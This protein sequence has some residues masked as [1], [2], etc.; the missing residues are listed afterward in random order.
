[1]MINLQRNPAE[2][3]GNLLRELFYIWQGEEIRITEQLGITMGELECLRQ[4]LHTPQLPIKD[5]LKLS[6]FNSSRLSKVLDQLEDNGY[7][8]RSI[9][10]KDRRN[11]F[12]TLSEK[13]KMA[14]LEIQTHMTRFY[15][16]I[17]EQLPSELNAFAIL[18]LRE[19]LDVLHQRMETSPLEENNLS[20][21]YNI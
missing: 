6:D 8:N 16:P 13:G 1:M 4:F 19:I 2:E 3:I 14:V 17:L 15:Q 11:T 21:N 12:V 7:I 9:D 5:L 10:Q 18:T 20:E